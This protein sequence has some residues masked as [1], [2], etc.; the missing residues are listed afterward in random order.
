[1]TNAV[2]VYDFTVGADVTTHTDLIKILRKIS[3]K[4]CFQLE[5]GE[6]GYRHYQGRFSLKVKKR[7]K[8]AIDLVGIPQAHLSITSKENRTNVFY[9]TKEETRIE[10]P[11]SDKDEQLYIPRQVREIETLYPWQQHIVDNYDVW[12]TRTI[13]VIVDTVGN[14]GKTILTSYMRAHKMAFKIPFCNDF[15]DILRMVADVPIKRCYL[16]DMPRG[17]KKDKLFQLFSAIEEVKNGYAYDD[18]YH[19]KEVIFDCPNIWIFM[20]MMPDIAMLSK[21]RWKFWEIKNLE[22]IPYQDFELEI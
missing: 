12:D 16:I 17:I 20:N 7:L 21:D 14:N 22:L 2:C 3:K 8:A 13:N 11:W 18:R 9:V 1:M 15:K 6:S 10:G 5:E 19:F 4:F